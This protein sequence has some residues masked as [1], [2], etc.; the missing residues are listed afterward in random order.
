MNSVRV[1]TLSFLA[2][3][4]MAQNLP[5]PTGLFF[6]PLLQG[7]SVMPQ[8]DGDKII[9]RIANHGTPQ[10]GEFFM[11]FQAVNVSSALAT[12]PVEFFDNNGEAMNLPLAASSDDLIG[13]P[14]Y[15]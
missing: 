9:P 8:D 11:I 2:P 5:R 7:Q 13:R 1:V 4:S 12:F 15:G 10:D 14:A 6:E 3:N